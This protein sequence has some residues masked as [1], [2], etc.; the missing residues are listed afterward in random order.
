MLSHNYRLRLQF[1]C[2]RI[3]KSEEVKLEDMIWAEKLAKANKS[4]LSMLNQARRKAHNPDM[5]E[6]RL[7]RLY[8]YVGSWRS[9][10]SK[11]SDHI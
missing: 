6:G 3:A 8:E 5:P 10:S 9:R 11:P 2:D 1:I 4:A 7:R